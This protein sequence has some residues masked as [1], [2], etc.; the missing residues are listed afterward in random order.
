MSLY[1]VLARHPMVAVISNH[2]DAYIKNICVRN[3]FFKG[4]AAAPVST[5]SSLE[6][7]G[8]WV[9]EHP[10]VTTLIVVSVVAVAGIAV[11]YMFYPHLLGFAS[12]VGG[13][14]ANQMLEDQTRLAAKASAEALV[15]TTRQLAE[16]N[17]R[18]ALSETSKSLLQTELTEKG[19]E[20]I[21]ERGLRVAA[22]TKIGLLQS[23][24]VDKA[25]EVVAAEAQSLKLKSALDIKNLLQIKCTED[26]RFSA[27]LLTQ[28]VAENP[29]QLG[30]GMSMERRLF[31]LDTFQDS[32]QV[33]YNVGNNL[34][35][36]TPL[37]PEVSLQAVNL[38]DA[39]INLTLQTYF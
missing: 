9:Q 32:V 1:V 38:A 17:A 34:P 39:C 18:L 37:A 20:V 29:P 30:R 15:E 6:N 31:V 8:I 26:E 22:E 7:A 23:S 5:I 21:A 2:L 16:A 36:G 11:T 28:I 13:A 25:S 4:F 10:I 14:G 24:L 27:H 3:N 12:A 19:S 35:I 33:A